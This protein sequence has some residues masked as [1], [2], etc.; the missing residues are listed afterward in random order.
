MALRLGFGA[1]NNKSEYEAILAGIELAATVSTDR[2][3]IRSDLQL[4]VG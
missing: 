1:S 3:L 2:L 4:V